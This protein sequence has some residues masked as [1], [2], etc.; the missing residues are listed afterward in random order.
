MMRISSKGLVCL[1][2]LMLVVAGCF[3]GLTHVAGAASSAQTLFTTQ[4]PA[5]PSVHVGPYEL[6]TELTSSVSGHITAI[7]FWKSSSETGQH[8][9]RIWSASGQ[10]LAS[11]TFASE[12]ASGWQQQFLASPLAIA[13]NTVY[14]V[15]V[16]S[17]SN[18]YYAA[19]TT[20]LATQVIN[21]NLSTVLGNNGVYGPVG[22]FPTN[23]YSQ[24]NY[25]RDIVFSPD[26]TLF[27]TQTPALPSVHVGPYELGTKFTS[28]ISGSITAIRFW[29]SS[30]ET[31]QHIGRI[32]SASGQLLAS[33]TFASETASGWQQQ[34]LASPLAIA[35]NTVYVVSV[36]SGSNAYYAA[37]TTGLATQVINQ[38][39]ST[40]LGNNGVYGP[41]GQFPTNTYSQSNYFRDI[42]FSAGSS[43]TTPGQPAISVVPASASFGGVTIGTTNTQT[44]T[45]SNHGTSN[46][47][48]SQATISGT[49]F[50]LSNL[51]LPLTVVPGNSA[52]FTVSFTP[53]TTTSTTG[54]LTLVSNAPT[55]PTTIA[56]SGTGVT[57]T[58][59]LTAS[60]TSLSFGNVTVGSSSSQTV[61]LSNTGNTS[62]SVS[63]GSVSGAGFAIS[64]L[65]SMSLG[66][67]QSTTFNVNFA[68][69]TTGS[70]SGS[71]LV[72][73]NA[74][75]SPTQ[76]ALTGSGVQPSAP[77][78]PVAAFPG[79]QGGGAL[80]VGGRGGVVYEVTNLNDS[81]SG[82][83]RACVIASGPRTCVFRTGGTINLVSSLIITNPFI[84][85]AGQ[86][87]PGGGIQIIG[88]TI[89]SS[90][91]HIFQINTHDVILRY[92]RLHPMYDSIDAS[93][94]GDGSS[95]LIGNYGDG[96]NTI[97]DHCSL[98]YPHGESYNTWSNDVPTTNKRNQTLSWSILGKAFTDHPTPMILGSAS[99]AG[100][101]AM[102]DIDYHHNLIATD[103]HRF[104]LFKV[105]NGRAV[106]NLYYGW[107]YYA[108]L[109]GGGARVDYINNI[110]KP[111][112]L[113]PAPGTAGSWEIT[114][115]SAPTC[116][117][118]G[119]SG[120][121]S[122]YMT[123]NLGPNDPTGANNAANMFRQDSYEGPGTISAAPSSWIRSTPQGAGAGI[124]ITADPTTNLATNV[125][126]AVGA[127][128]KLNDVAC[129]GTFVNNRDSADTQMVDE[130]NAGTGTE[131]VTNGNVTLPTLAAGTPCT[132]SLDDGIANQWKIK[133]GLSITD[134]SLYK[135]TAPNGY[136]YLENYLNGA[137]P[138]VTASANS[139][140]SLWAAMF[141]PKAKMGSLMKENHLDG[142]RLSRSVSTNFFDPAVLTWLAS[143]TGGSAGRQTTVSRVSGALGGEEKA[144]T[145]SSSQ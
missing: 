26:P 98:Q 107:W 95:I 99:Q 93:G 87:A 24:S 125:L 86:T 37:T 65:T 46:L 118:C 38:N 18:A 31:G 91:T 142:T 47:S 34:S 32:W 45:V 94:S 100:S 121:P 9:G 40:V 8:I 58:M 129:D 108:S 112:P 84:T 130:Y 15:S 36:N 124:A 57:T 29:K 116:Q 109:S 59:Q 133:Y 114:A 127:S 54:A 96:Y 76:I 62:V 13:A 139:T 67:G 134:A 43:S 77:A 75:N 83:L 53:T 128:E 23:T 35:A 115:Y 10:L 137:D 52:A 141:A 60:P 92:L 145:F 140:A 135:T 82:S 106:N 2:L 30:S 17:G 51:Q 122:I 70:V 80:S 81:G 49:G 104:P 27:T 20:G 12:T 14:V 105:A 144:H 69:T 123:G 66:A 42:V 72:A 48:V 50:K 136:T 39:L 101:A 89:T 56:L 64:G 19:T 117:T 119:P 7:R 90:P 28:N 25:F 22:Q 61:K 143:D 21:Q 120:A 85:I 113:T 74:T 111:G 4:T 110:Y 44:I 55:S 71:A 63:G 16:N 132:S 131:P 3:S 33:V 6:G 78:G 103:A 97:V 102:T 11:V 138:N 5:L 88:T 126:N 79:A 41:V 68:P 1:V 73:G